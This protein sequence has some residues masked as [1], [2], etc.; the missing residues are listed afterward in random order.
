MSEY[1]LAHHGV[2]GMKWGIRRYQPYPKGY[3]GSG[4]EI[5]EARKRSNRADE[6]RELGK[7]YTTPFRESL[8]SSPVELGAHVA[9]MLAPPAIGAPLI[10]ASALNNIRRR[11]IHKFDRTNYYKKDGPPEKL[12]EL[13]KKTAPD[14]TSSDMNVVNLNGKKHTAGRVNNCV[15]CTVAM[16]MRARGYDVLARRSGHGFTAREWSNWYKDIKW[17]TLSD[18]T[19][20]KRGI[21]NSIKNATTREDRTNKAFYEMTDRIEKLPKNARGTVLIT[22]EGMSGSPAGGHAMFWKNENGRATFYDGQSKKVDPEKVFGLSI[23]EST[24]WARLDNLEVKEGITNQIMSRKDG[25][26]K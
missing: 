20:P 5:G 6:G 11:K 8:K 1:Y 23:M 13:R 12:S 7:N 15:N 19:P 18:S 24:L 22:Y 4:K 21:T 3:R 2:L 16:D 10:I 17:E 14:N 26:Q 9:L 25:K